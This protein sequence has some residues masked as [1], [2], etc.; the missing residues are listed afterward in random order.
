MGFFKKLFT[1]IGFTAGF[2][3][4][5]CLSVI[6]YASRGRHKPC[7]RRSS[8]WNTL[9]RYLIFSWICAF[10]RQPPKRF[11]L[12]QSAPT[13]FWHRFVLPMLSVPQKDAPFSLVLPTALHL[14]SCFLPPAL[15]FSPQEQHF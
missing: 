13:R 4:F 9:E 6:V 12:V 2:L 7:H 3:F 1:G 5:G 14:C 8:F 11:A 10:L 15:V